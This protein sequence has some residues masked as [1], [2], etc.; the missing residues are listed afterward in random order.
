MLAMADQNGIVAASLPGLARLARIDRERCQDALETMLAPDQYSR[1]PEF[2]GRRIERV[3]GGWKLLNHA[4]YMR[5]LSKEDRREYNAQ[6][7]RESRERKHSST[8]V[9]TPVDKSNDVSTSAHRDRDLDRDTDKDGEKKAL[10]TPSPLAF[11]GQHF[12]L[13]EKHDKILGDAFPWVNRIAEYKKADSWIEGHPNKKPK[14]IGA[15]LHNWFSKVEAPSS[16]EHKSKEQ[17]RHERGEQ[18]TR[19]VLGSGSKLAEYLR[20]GVSRGEERGTRPG[21]PDS[22]RGS[23]A[24]HPAQGV[25]AGH[26]E[27]EVPPN[28]GGNRT[29]G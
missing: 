15:F 23:A 9:N 17:M 22:P 3:E 26:E 28:A 11:S 16:P 4:K 20:A 1:S 21:L 25:L 14:R 19:N 27:I 8:N 13:T 18:A 2:E 29:G 24:G 10:A 12:K 7:Q 6:K 5:L